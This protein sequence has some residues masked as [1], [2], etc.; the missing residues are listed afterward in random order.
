MCGIYRVVQVL[1]VMTFF[2]CSG[3]TNNSH[4]SKIWLAT[5]A[6]PLYRY[7]ACMGAFHSWWW[8]QKRKKIIIIT[9]TLYWTATT[10][11]SSSSSSSS[12]F[13]HIQK[14]KKKKR[15]TAHTCVVVASMQ[16]D[17][18]NPTDKHQP[19]SIC[20]YCIYTRGLLPHCCCCFIIFFF[21]R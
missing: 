4:S 5:K 13:N 11:G 18:M 7:T 3:C 10:S 8:P 14:E 2:C 17:R 20:M 6:P 12:T 16:Y 9:S 19:L 1:T 15:G 21:L